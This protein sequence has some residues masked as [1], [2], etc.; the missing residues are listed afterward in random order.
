M[1][2][3]VT[4]MLMNKRRKGGLQ[5]AVVDVDVYVR[6]PPMKGEAQPMD[7]DD[8]KWLK[9]DLKAEKDRLKMYGK[10]LDNWVP[11]DVA[12]KAKADVESKMAECK[13]RIQ[14]L[15]GRI[16]LRSK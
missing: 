13:L 10:V 7:V 15:K 11:E 8:T 12:A 5:K 16:N 14:E 3:S 1:A 6:T 2:G 4:R 9:E